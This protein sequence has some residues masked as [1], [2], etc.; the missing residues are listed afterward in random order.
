MRQKILEEFQ[1]A[2]AALERW[3]SATGEEGTRLALDAAAAL[4]R[5]AASL[6]QAAQSSTAEV[7]PTNGD[8]VLLMR[9]VE[10]AYYGAL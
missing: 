6:R 3:Q 7:D 2:G 10:A 5:T 8:F 1:N 4:E 9:R